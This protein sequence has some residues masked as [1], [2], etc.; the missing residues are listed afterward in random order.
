MFYDRVFYEE[1]KKHYKLN[2][3]HYKD[4][5]IPKKLVKK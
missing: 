5:N 4:G 2:L 1:L 3:E